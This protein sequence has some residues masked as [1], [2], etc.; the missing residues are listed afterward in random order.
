MRAAC[1][2]IALLLFLPCCPG[3]LAEEP[4]ITVSDMSAFKPLICL[5]PTR[6]KAAPACASAWGRSRC[7]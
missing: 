2:A 6:R 1:G 7:A 3:A 5:A 4:E